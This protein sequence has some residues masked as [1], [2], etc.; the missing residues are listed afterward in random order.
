ATTNLTVTVLWKVDLDE[1][2]ARNYASAFQY[3][4]PLSDPSREDNRDV[5]LFPRKLA[6]AGRKQ[7]VCLHRPFQPERFDAGCAGTPPSIFVA[8]ADRLDDFSGPK[9]V[10][11]LL[12]APVLPWEKNRLGASWVPIE[13]GAEEWLLPYHG[14][15]DA[16]VGYTQSF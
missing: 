8:C 13:L 9:A 12:A 2:F 5:F 3:V 7:Y 11:R 14:K 10:H 16:D 1:L 6:I 15:Q 4:G